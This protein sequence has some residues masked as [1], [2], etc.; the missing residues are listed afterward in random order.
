MKTAAGQKNWQKWILC[1][2]A[3]CFLKVCRLQARKP[4]KLTN[5]DKVQAG[6]FLKTK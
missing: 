2:A 3:G 5:S 6:M 4:E 1:L